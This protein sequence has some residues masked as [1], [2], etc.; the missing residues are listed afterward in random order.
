MNKLEHF[1]NEVKQKNIGLSNLEDSDMYHSLKPMLEDKRYIFIGESGHCVKEYTIA[2]VNLIKYLHENLGFNVIA[3]ESELGDCTIGDHIAKEIDPHDFMR[4][5]IG[6]IWHNE[7]NLELFRYIQS[8]KENYPLYFTGIDVQQSENKHFVPF[9]LQHIRD[10]HLKNHFQE[11]DRAMTKILNLKRIKKSMVLKEVDEIKEKIKLVI[12]ELEAR[13]VSDSN[14][15]KVIIRTLNNRIDHLYFIVENGFA[16]EFQHR[17]KMMAENLEFIVNELYPG[18]KVIVCAHNL[19][20]K[21]KSSSN[22]LASYSSFFENLPGQIQE[23]SFVIGM[24]AHK[25]RMGDYRGTDYPIKKANKKNLEWLLSHSP[26]QN[27]FIKSNLSWGHKKWRAFEGGV[28]RM[29]FLPAEQ[30][31]GILFFKEVHPIL[32]KPFTP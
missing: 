32:F 24:Y 29:S 2:K 26:C 23:N 9:I 16:K 1:I 10:Q 21:R 27:F 6:R 22:R 30:Y 13:P 14:L 7:H 15:Q 11:A 5:T 8:M 3:F 4:G 20:I 19:H 31:D 18:E 17:E 28:T 12:E 25:G